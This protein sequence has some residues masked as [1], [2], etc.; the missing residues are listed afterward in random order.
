MTPLIINN[1]LPVNG[2]LRAAHAHA[3]TALPASSIAV[4]VAEDLSNISTRCLMDAITCIAASVVVGLLRDGM[5]PRAG[6][7]VERFGTSFSY[8]IV[9]R[10]LLFSFEQST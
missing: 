7:V 8:I 10:D 1:S 3:H 6:S 9:S 5:K 4:V 2:H